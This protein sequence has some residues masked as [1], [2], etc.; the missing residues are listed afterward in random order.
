MK[1]ISALLSLVL[2]VCASRHATAQETLAAP[3]I[4][5]AG[6]LPESI[7]GDEIGGTFSGEAS[8]RLVPEPMA[9]EIGEPGGDVS[10]L[11]IPSQVYEMCP[12]LFESSG[13]W[14]KRGFWYAEADYVLLNRQWDRHGLMLMFETT[15]GSVPYGLIGGPLGLQSGQPQTLL[16]FNELTIRGGKPG[17][18]G[19]ARTTIGRFLFRDSENRDHVTQFTWWGGGDFAQNSQITASTAGLTVTPFIDRTNNSFDGAQS[20]QFT[21]HTFYDSFEWNYMVRQRMRKDQLLL[22]PDG[23]WVRSANPSHT[24]GLIAGT[25]FVNLRETFTWNA[26]GIPVNTTTNPVTRGVGSYNLSSD[27]DMLGTQLG[28]TAATEHSRWSVTMTAKAG[29]Y[30]NSMDLNSQRVVPART[31]ANAA[32]SAPANNANFA[33]NEDNLSFI[34]EAQILGRWHL[35]P[36]MSIRAGLELMYISGVALAPHQINFQPGGY[37][38]IADG[39]DLTLMGSSLGFEWYH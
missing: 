15:T 10:F 27:N 1:I 34:S 7:G 8:G 33:S 3:S 32:S 23:N 24:F 11:D 28:I 39:G 25:R 22:Q 26:Q 13:T 17:G 38:P 20:A 30:W 9:E 21:Y 29:P 6:S 37:F 36:N 2:L 16:V 31:G 4:D 35:R 5:E 12:A 14:L 18:E 19:T